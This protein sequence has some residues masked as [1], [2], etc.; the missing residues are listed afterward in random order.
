[1]TG[2]VPTPESDA[3]IVVLYLAEIVDRG[4]VVSMTAGTWK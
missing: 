3:Q 2:F 1:M 4:Q